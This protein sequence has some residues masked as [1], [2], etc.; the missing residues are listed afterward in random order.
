MPLLVDEAE[1]PE[2]LSC[3]APR[4][5]RSLGIDQEV[6]F[7]LRNPK[8]LYLE[9]P[10]TVKKVVETAPNSEVIPQLH[11]HFYRKPVLVKA[12]NRPRK[13]ETLQS[14]GVYAVVTWGKP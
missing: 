2:W 9:R 7:E 4:T 12:R 14:S 6:P 11:S 3:R 8:P 10:N 5:Q 1:Y 13:K